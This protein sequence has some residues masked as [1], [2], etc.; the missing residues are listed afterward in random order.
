MKH[1]YLLFVILIS[2]NAALAQSASVKGEITD[3]AANPIP[4][5]TVSLLQPA[6]STLAYFGISNKDGSFEIKDVPKGKYLLQAAFMG[7]KT[8][9]RTLELPLQGSDYIGRISLKRI[10]NQLKEVEIKTE[11][12]P[13]TI[14]RDT[15]EYNAGSFKTKPDA[16]VEELLKKLPGVQVDRAG[17]IKAQGED[18]RKVLVDGKPFFSNDP[19]VAT[20]NLPADAIN[21]VQVFNKH[22]DMSEFTGIDDGER[23]KT[24]NLQLKD[25]KKNGYFGDAQAG[26]GT[27]TRLDGSA[28]V[29]KF[30]P[31]TQLAAIGMVNNINH[32]GFSF[33]DY[34]NFN[35]GLSSLMNSGG[36]M[37]I[38]SGNR[39]SPP[40]DFGQPIYGLITS[41]A[42]GV[43]YSYEPRKNNRYNISYLGNGAD[44]NLV[45][46][47]NSRNFTDNGTYE[48][49]SNKDEQSYNI[50]H[51]LNFNVRNDKDSAS[52]YTANGGATL[53]NGHSQTTAY[54]TSL[55]EDMVLNSLDS[56]IYEKG[57]SVKAN[58]GLSYLL[59]SKSKKQVYKATAGIR[60]E[61]ELDKSE[62][63]NIT[64]I[65]PTNTT[66]NDMQKQDNHSVLSQYN[67]TVSVLQS[68]GRSYFLEPSLHAGYDAQHFDRIQRLT[69]IGDMQVDS[70]SPDFTRAYSW[71]Q[72]GV[73]LRRSKQ[74][75]QF[76]VALKASVGLLS[77]S[78]NGTD[79]GRNVYTYLLPS[80]NLQN[81]Y[82]SGK[83]RGV[84]YNSS[85]AAPE[86]SQLMPVSNYSNP[87]QVYTGNNNL[88]PEYIHNAGL[89]WMWFDQFSFSS[90]FA[91]IS[92][93]YT[94]DKITWSRTVNPDLSQQMKPANVPYEY[95]VR[96]RVEYSRPIR[97]I[98]LTVN[99]SFEEDYTRSI[100]IINSVN[101][102]VN[103]YNHRFEL[104]FGNKKKEKWDV[105]IGGSISI[106]DAKYELNQNYN[107]RFYSLTGF[108]EISYRPNTHWYFMLS[109][110]VTQYNASSFAGAI[111]V[112][113]MKS[114][115][116]YYFMKANR[117]VLTFSG[118]DLLNRNTGIQRSGQ[119]NFV[120][121]TRSNIIG[122]YFMLSFKYRIN[123]TGNS[124]PGGIQIKMK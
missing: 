124:N 8:Y 84:Y 37:N 2:G 45:E 47:S 72:P 82:S 94:A 52:Q 80:F 92:G 20:K 54:T 24:I 5:T 79:T 25:N 57:R 98:G 83:R 71:L 50:A 18:V 103:N 64:R 90:L 32:F 107:N 1:I 110:D 13:I 43:N 28:R 118:Y 51:R 105:N 48:R 115:M 108:G 99:T 122:Q 86:A 96:A 63:A 3:T 75:I 78:L 89:N 65:L 10:S 44:K 74:K 42:A 15:V 119:I 61:K 113:L 123:K 120:S 33:S 29:Y 53:S 19:K 101:N 95:S 68:L 56:R 6:D 111:L 31:K 114:E 4:Y 21:K 30:K 66:G 11:K 91:N 88:R 40:I 23:E 58:A 121:E 27:N 14:K 116:S 97:K 112:P 22:S 104:S 77:R 7:F 9:Y 106:T 85:V 36:Q 34:I 109:A 81:E 55:L 59:N 16:N 49:K 87:L 41:G 73:S 76:N 69:A 93:R 38:N 12:I 35:G 100:N 117:G 62:W 26:Y 39:D 67:G 70:L 17:N 102:N 46:S 60:Y